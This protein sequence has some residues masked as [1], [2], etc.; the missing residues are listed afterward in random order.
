MNEYYHL[1]SDIDSTITMCDET[2][3]ELI[4]AVV[5]PT[6][7]KFCPECL[8]MLFTHRLTTLRRLWAAMPSGTREYIGNYGA[9]RAALLAEFESALGMEPK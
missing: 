6:I 2:A 5:Y 8:D 9:E 4:N 3:N 1:V 7:S